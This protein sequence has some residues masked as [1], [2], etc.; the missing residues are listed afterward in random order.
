MFHDEWVRSVFDL[1]VE[2]LK[3]ECLESG[4][5]MAFELFRR[6]DIQAAGGHA[7]TYHGLAEEFDIPVT[8]V[9]NLLALARG[10]FREQVLCCLR[11]LSGTEEEFR[12]DV[13]ELLGVRDNA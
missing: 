5:E 8:Q 3:T 1:A 11:Q 9:T 6:Y 13:A 12:D 10:L 4:R 2:R 7:V